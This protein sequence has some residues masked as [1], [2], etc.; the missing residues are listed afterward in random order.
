MRYQRANVAG[1]I[2]FFTANLAGRKRTLL[3]DH[4]DVLVI[5]EHPYLHPN[6]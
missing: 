5:F 2:Y 6:R 1:G 3:T 4:I